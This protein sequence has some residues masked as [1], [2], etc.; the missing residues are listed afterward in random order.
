MFPAS[1]VSGFN[2]GVEITFF[3]SQFRGFRL[4]TPAAVRAQFGDQRGTAGAQWPEK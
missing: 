3:V 2:L 4:V 1:R